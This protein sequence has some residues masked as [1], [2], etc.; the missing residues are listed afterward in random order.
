MSKAEA[1]QLDRYVI[2][3]ADVDNATDFMP[4]EE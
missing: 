4:K 3:R 1:A 2:E